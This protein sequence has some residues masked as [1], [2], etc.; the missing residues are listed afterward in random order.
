MDINARPFSIL[1][2]EKMWHYEEVGLILFIICICKNGSAFINRT[3]GAMLF[4]LIIPIPFQLLGSRGSTLSDLKVLH[5]SVMMLCMNKNVTNC[6][7]I[8]SLITF[9]DHIFLGIFC[10]Q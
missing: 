10:A 9:A 6:N 8:C 1:P 3:V 5:E 7:T 2:F 4:F